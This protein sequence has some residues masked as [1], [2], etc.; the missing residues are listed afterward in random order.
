[1]VRDDNFDVARH[2]REA[3]AQLFQLLPA[4]SP[5]FTGERARCIH[6]RNRNLIIGIERLE[7]V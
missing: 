3:G 2:I 7:V 5:V 6:A 1:M 4:D